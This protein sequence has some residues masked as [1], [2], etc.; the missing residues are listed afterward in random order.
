MI[1]RRAQDGT[2]VLG[3]GALE[4]FDRYRQRN[5]T[6]PEAGGVLLGRFVQGTSDIIVDDATPPG[7]GDTA[8]RFTFRRSRRRAQAIVAQVWRES[9]GTRNYLGEWHTHPEDA[10]SPSAVD[11]ANWQRIVATARYEQNSLFFVIVGLKN[12][13]TWEVLR[14]SRMIIQLS[15]SDT[16]AVK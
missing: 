3:E 2:V 9:G 1:F 7:D 15:S 4:I 11:L 6:A 8:S 12:I 10:P 13:G 5:R 14:S 16:D